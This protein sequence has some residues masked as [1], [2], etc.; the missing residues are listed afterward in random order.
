MRGR[1]ILFQLFL[2][3]T[4]RMFNIDPEKLVHAELLSSFFA[5]N[6]HWNNIILSKWNNMQN[7]IHVTM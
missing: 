3:F 1:F 5:F 7:I 2:I 4:L 6:Y